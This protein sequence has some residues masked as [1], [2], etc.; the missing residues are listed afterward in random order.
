M[1][2]TTTFPKV[3]RSILML[4]PFLVASAWLAGCPRYRCSG[5]YDPCPNNW[6]WVKTY[7]KWVQDAACEGCNGPKWGSKEGQ[8]YPVC[9]DTTL[10]QPAPGQCWFDCSGS[11][12]NNTLWYSWT[13]C[14]LLQEQWECQ[15]EECEYKTTPREQ[16]S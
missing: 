14:S 2:S 5:P 13:D 6:G 10:N 16:I 4:V 12:S 7:C 9:W 15:R 1:K 3:T 11:C 8:G